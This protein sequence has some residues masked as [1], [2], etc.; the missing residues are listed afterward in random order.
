MGAQKA[1]VLGIM[2][3]EDDKR[4]VDADYAEL[5][6]KMKIMDGD[7]Q[8]FAKHADGE[9]AKESRNLDSLNKENARLQ[10]EV[11]KKEEQPHVDMRQQEMM[12]LN[13]QLDVYTRKIEVEQRKVA[14]LSAQ[15]EEVKSNIKSQQHDIL[16]WSGRSGVTNAAK[17]SNQAIQKQ[18]RQLENRLEKAL[19]KFN[20]ALAH[21]KELREEIDGLRRER[22]VFDSIYKKL[23]RELDHKKKEM[24]NIIEISNS[25]YESRDQAQQEMQ[26]LKKQ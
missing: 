5:Q 26:A 25:A 24:A 23:E 17:D 1:A 11:T 18:I 21:N 2:A 4:S 3:G 6:R 9:M 7:R 16:E 20:E 14:E 19:V 10:K 12:R 15:V 8:K 22:V 13:D